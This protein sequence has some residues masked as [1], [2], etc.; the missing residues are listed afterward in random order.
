M[1]KILQQ[2]CFLL[3]FYFDV[4]SGRFVRAGEERARSITT[5]TDCNDSILPSE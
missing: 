3:N 2:K 5:N 1:C 4:D